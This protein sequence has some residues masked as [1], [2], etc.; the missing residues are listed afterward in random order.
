M[1][2]RLCPTLC[3]SMDCDLTGCSVDEILQ[4]RILEWVAI[5]SS[6]G[7]SPPRNWTLVFRVDRWTLPLS[8]LRSEQQLSNQMKKKH[9]F[10]GHWHHCVSPKVLWYLGNRLVLWFLFLLSSLLSRSPD[11]NSLK[12]NWDFSG[13]ESN[14][15]CRRQNR[16]G[17]DSWVRKIPW[18]KKQ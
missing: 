2:A 8:H 11:W 9:H 13:K 14:C 18:S 6:R 15:Q 1:H 7:S 4:A 10:R 5:S 3:E 16:Y 17:F 12:Q